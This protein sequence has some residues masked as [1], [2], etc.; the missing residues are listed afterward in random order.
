M[1]A[2][3]GHVAPIVEYRSR[4][5]PV[6]LGIDNMFADHFE[7][8]RA[9]V[10]AARIKTGDPTGSAVPPRCCASPP[11][12]ARRPSGWGPRSAPSSPA[13]GPISRCWT[14]GGFGLTPNL[15]PVRNLVYHAHSKDVELVM[16]DGNVLVEDFELKTAG[17]GPAHRRCRCGGGGGVGPLRGE[18]RRL[19]GALMRCTEA[20]GRSGSL[21]R[22]A[23]AAGP[24]PRVDAARR[25][26]PRAAA[27]LAPPAGSSSTTGGDRMNDAEA[28][29]RRGEAAIRRAPGGGAVHRPAGGPSPAEPRGGARDPG[30]P[31]A[32]QRGAR[33][34]AARRL[35][36]GAHHPRHAT[37]RRHR[38]PLRGRHP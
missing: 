21:K 36:G 4:G 14:T 10:S 31:A 32:A 30:L 16:V 12:R 9:C 18:I 26:G 28:R 29:G 37:A 1:N 3:R 25:P 5:I 11:W 6:T 38:P 24:A 27:G 33:A 13:S 22:D 7:V 34:R 2:V 15:D 23:E 19:H 17:R 20:A 35:E 8:L